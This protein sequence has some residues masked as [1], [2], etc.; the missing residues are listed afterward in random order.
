MTYSPVATLATLTSAFTWCAPPRTFSRTKIS[1][2]S[3]DFLFS[4]CRASNVQRHA[5]SAQN[6]SAS[7]LLHEGDRVQLLGT[8][9]VVDGNMNLLLEAAIF[10]AAD[11][12]Q[13]AHNCGVVQRSRSVFAGPDIG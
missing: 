12:A 7:V 9:G 8:P 13:F 2:T 11:L 3:S 10:G 1:P 5:C 6:S 4:C